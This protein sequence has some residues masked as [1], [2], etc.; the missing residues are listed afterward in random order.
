MTQFKTDKSH[1]TE[2][3]VEKVRKEAKIAQVS[4]ATVTGS[5]SPVNHVYGDVAV[6]KDTVFGAAS[7]SKPVFSY[8]ILKLVEAG[9]LTL[10]MNGLNDIL[11][12]KSFCEQ[13]GF[14]WKNNEEINEVPQ[15]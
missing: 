14:K 15:L 11:P 7:L 1:I 8:L 2:S 10:D 12:F 6:D 4:V 9:K 13:H 5:G 3:D